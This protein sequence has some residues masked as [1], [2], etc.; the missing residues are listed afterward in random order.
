MINE[1]KLTEYYGE[2][3]N[4]MDNIIPIEWDK[5][6]LFLE[7]L[8]DFRTAQFMYYSGSEIKY[9]TAIPRDFGYN[10]AVERKFDMEFRELRKIGERIRKEFI[11]SDEEPWTTM[12]FYID[13]EWNFEIKFGYAPPDYTLNDDRS[14]YGL[15]WA[16]NIL[17]ITPEG[18][19]DA[20]ELQD[21]LD[22][23]KRHEE[24]NNN[25]F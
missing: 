9:C 6:V 8:G 14:D 16:M 19:E 5:I 23:I 4:S 12:A 7:D 25:L 13:S 10:D 24:E 22:F 3:A 15:G 1:M 20:K 2:M 17:E 11:N 18:E 21:Y